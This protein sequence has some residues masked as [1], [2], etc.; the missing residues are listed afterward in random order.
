MT[1]TVTSKA[2]ENLAMMR[3]VYDAFGTGDVETAGSFWA[4][5]AKHHYPGRSVLA[6][7]H[8]GVEDSTAFANKMFELTE[9][10]LSMEVVDLAASDTHAYALLQ[11]H[12]ERGEKTLD[13]M[14]VNMVR[15]ENGRIA[16]FWTMPQDQYAVDEFWGLA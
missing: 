5:D 10:K 4:E 13:V 16:E 1:T 14:F 7:T 6:G 9:G 2:D 11:T 12:Y 8:H 15:I 3:K